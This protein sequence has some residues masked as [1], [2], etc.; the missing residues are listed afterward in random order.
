MEAA[1][2]N[3]QIKRQITVGGKTYEMPEKM[4]TMAYLHYLEVRD[5]VMDTEATQRLY[6]RQQF[7]DMMDVII[8]MYGN[9][10]TKE[11]ML[12]A[13]SGMTP[14]EIITEFALMDVSVGQNVDRKVEDFKGNFTAGK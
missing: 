11:D 3:K 7:I 2:T 5:A 12:D 10:F 4:S 6:T 14:E 1:T 8:E 13:E 9:R